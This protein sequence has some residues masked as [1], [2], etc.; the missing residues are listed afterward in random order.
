MPA[1]LG[2]TATAVDPDN[3]AVKQINLGTVITL[4]GK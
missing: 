4:R 3:G 2:A 1:Q